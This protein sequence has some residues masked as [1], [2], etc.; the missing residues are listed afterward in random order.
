MCKKIIF[1]LLMVSGFSPF[2]YA[3]S[4]DCQK[5]TTSV[6]K[7]VC[8]S[9]VL[10]DLDKNLAL[11]YKRAMELIKPEG[12]KSIRQS[13]RDWIKRRDNSWKL[14][15]GDVEILKN[16]Y[17]SRIKYFDTVIGILLKSG[18]EKNVE[19]SPNLNVK[20]SEMFDTVKSIL[21]KAEGF[22]LHWSMNAEG[23]W[24]AQQCE[25][26]FKQLMTPSD[27]RVLEPNLYAESSVDPKIQ[28][29]LN[30]PSKD[31]LS[32]SF[33]RQNQE[34]YYP[35]GNVEL[36]FDDPALKGFSYLYVYELTN[37]LSTVDLAGL[38]FMYKPNRTLNYAF[39]HGNGELSSG[40]VDDVYFNPTFLIDVSGQLLVVSL[41]QNSSKSLIV[42]TIKTI[43]KNFSHALKSCTFT[44][45]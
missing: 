30:F 29:Y 41:D 21:D 1:T 43:S 37:E 6:E 22:K 23:F 15:K 26:A 5:A 32:M 12:T 24:T 33:Q 11:N 31:E 7:E 44:N 4:F 14:S 9:N 8:K 16:D 28:T 39:N 42:L 20:K 13:Q 17:L 25:Q 35:S 34:R 19:P 38:Y 2:I 10:G 40:K 18:A 3:A 45:Y 27:T 36:Y